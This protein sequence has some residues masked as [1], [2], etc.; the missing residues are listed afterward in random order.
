M[1][2]P[3]A[4]DEGRQ[5]RQK[6]K[7]EKARRKQRK[8]KG[9]S[10]AHTSELPPPASAAHKWVMGTAV[11]LPLVGTVLAMVLLVA[12]GSLGWWHVA[13]VVGGWLA[14]GLGIT[15]GFHRLL[16]HRSFDTYHGVRFIWA[17]L[18]ACSIEGSPLVWC[19]IHRR[20]HNFSDEPGDPHSPHQHGTGV[21]GTLRGLL[22]AQVGWLFTG[23][24]SS[25]ELQRY[26]PDLMAQRY[27]V[28]IDRWYYLCVIASLGVPALLGGLI[29]RS[30]YGAL[31]GL[32]WGGLVRILITHHITW[33]INSVCH[34]FGFKTYKAGDESRNNL[35]C[36]VLGHGEGWHNNH[37]AFPTSARHGLEWWQF[38]L[39]WLIIRGMQAVG[40]AWNVRLPEAHTMA[41]RKLA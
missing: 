14:T 26:V 25:P 24:W 27:L 38:D 37:H 15:V 17:M 13:M 23:Y 21:W 12:S 30:W 33:S 35:I 22:H 2:P 31:M 36:G 6:S 18:G 41:A 9:T 28:A 1:A 7:K 32:L 3:T 34:V 11:V 10:R 8:A 29:E 4:L 20:H 5:Q 39:S 40:L 16:T 19:A